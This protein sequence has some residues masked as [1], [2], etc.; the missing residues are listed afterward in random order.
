MSNEPNKD[1]NTEILGEALTERPMTRDKQIM[2]LQ[3]ALARIQA[4]SR[5]SVGGR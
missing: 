4:A 3:D 1:A 5:S 2:E